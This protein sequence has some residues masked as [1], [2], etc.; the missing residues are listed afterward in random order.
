MPLNCMQVTAEEIDDGSV[1][2][3]KYIPAEVLV[4]LLTN[5]GVASNRAGKQSMRR[6][7]VRCRPPVR[8][9]LAVACALTGFMGTDTAAQGCAGEERP[10]LVCM[11]FEG[12]YML[13]DLHSKSGFCPDYVST[14]RACGIQG[15]Q[16]PPPLL[17]S[18][19]VWRI[20]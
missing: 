13:S 8:L 2:L 16:V 4:D 9:I 6:K 10:P 3:S 14:W 19:C 12:D 20:S 11:P 1:L 17:S 15:L 18:P 5:T 7:K